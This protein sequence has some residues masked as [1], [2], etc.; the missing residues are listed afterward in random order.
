MSTTEPDTSVLLTVAVTI[1]S[2]RRQQF[3]DS[4]RE[5]IRS[6]RQEPGVLGYRVST[7]L[8]D[9]HTFVFVERYRS[10]EALE[11]HLATPACQAYLTGLPTW[12]AEPA[13]ARVEQAARIDLID[14][15]P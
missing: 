14:V 10:T 15:A 8:D 3:L 1:R 7:D 6:A 2:P 4:V 9:E 5:L 13:Q 11:A 12:L